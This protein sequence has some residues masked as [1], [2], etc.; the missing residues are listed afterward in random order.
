[1]PEFM[2][3]N[4]LDYV[5]GRCSALTKSG[6]DLAKSTVAQT[7]APQTAESISTTV[8]VVDKSEA[9]K[10][11]PPLKKAQGGVSTD[12]GE[13]E[14]PKA[15][16]IDK[17]NTVQTL[18]LAES[19]AKKED[20]FEK[21]ADARLAQIIASASSAGNANKQ[22]AEPSKAGINLPDDNSS[23]QGGSS[24]SSNVVNGI[25][26][27]IPEDLKWLEELRLE[28]LAAFSDKVDILKLYTFEE[29]EDIAAALASAFG[30]VM[31]LKCALEDSP[32]P[33]PSITRPSGRHRDPKDLIPSAW[34]NY[35]SEKKLLL[36]ILP[37]EALDK[38]CTLSDEWTREQI[39]S[40]QHLLMDTGINEIFNYLI[41]HDSP[42]RAHIFSQTPTNR[43][44]NSLNSY[45]IAKL[46]FLATHKV[47]KQKHSFYNLFT[48]RENFAEFNNS[49]VQSDF[50]RIPAMINRF[51]K[52]NKE[53]IWKSF[54]KAYLYDMKAETYRQHII[55]FGCSRWE[56]FGA[57]KIF[58]SQ[59]LCERREISD[60]EVKEIE[61][62]ILLATGLSR[63]ILHL[64]QQVYRFALDTR[65]MEEAKLIEMAREAKKA[66]VSEMEED[67]IAFDQIMHTILRCRVDAREM[68][69]EEIARMIKGI[70]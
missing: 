59:L 49:E 68:A 62:K 29:A 31:D 26:F 15:A 56:R 58:L 42:H 13:K 69:A 57:A 44:W 48:A 12:S 4:I 23:G 7:L 32:P 20:S 40:I 1:M 10:E 38:M 28:V 41:P 30:Y 45:A 8:K 39:E 37:K 36:K 43:P 63:E 61:E 55:G 54:H 18:G 47:L 25:A 34:K 33:Q 70:Y 66:K 17:S 52:A 14:T 50:G 5:Q 16:E 3:D 9:T 27:N 11:K 6:S 51:L 19:E 46:A 22:G 24:L 21:L 35:F 64:Y 60:E 2:L 65:R 67:K 53:F